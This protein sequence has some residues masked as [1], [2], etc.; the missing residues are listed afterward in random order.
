METKNGHRTSRSL[1]PP[2]V[3]QALQ[4]APQAAALGVQA[5]A[6]LHTLLSVSELGGGCLPVALVLAL[7]LVPRITVRRQSNGRLDQSDIVQPHHI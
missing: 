6:Q 1:S 4:V 5:P 2:H 7:A 3:A